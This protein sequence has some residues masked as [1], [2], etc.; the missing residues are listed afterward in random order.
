MLFVTLGA[1]PARLV[2]FRRSRRLIGAPHQEERPRRPA[3]EHQRPIP[4]T[5]TATPPDLARAALIRVSEGGPADAVGVG[6]DSSN[7]HV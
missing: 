3:D 2:R 5:A 4:Q 6:A 7:A 1:G